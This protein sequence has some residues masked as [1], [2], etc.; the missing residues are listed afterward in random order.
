MNKY[1]IGILFNVDPIWMG[2]VIYILNCV[3]ALNLLNEED[4]PEV[5]VF[6]T[7]EVLKYLDG[8]TY[9]HAFYIEIEKANRFKDFIMSL[10]TRRNLHLRRLLKLK[11]VDSVFPVFDI[12][13]K[14]QLG[15]KAV[16]W[17]ADFQYRYYPENFAKRRRLEKELRAK[18]VSK[19]AR[20]VVFSSADAAQDYGRFYGSHK[21]QR[22]SVYRFCSVNQ[23]VESQLVEQVRLKFNLNES[24]F[25]CSNQWH[26]HKNH[27]V[28]LMALERCIQSDSSMKVVLT[29]KPYDNQELPHMR[30]IMRLLEL[31][32]IKNN[33]VLTGLIDRSEQIALMQGARAVIQPSLFEGWSTV[34]EDAMSLG[35]PLVLSNLEVNREQVGD[36]G[37]FFNPNDHLELANILL[38]SALLD[39]ARKMA[40]SIDYE[41]RMRKSAYELYA[42]LSLE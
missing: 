35:V 21:L 1:R 20:H 39:N 6:Y 16:C 3:N 5:T 34:C 9:P 7:K 22:V 14:D 8:I 42:A 40:I 26:P 32:S 31:P 29:G 13:C 38:N 41:A 17:I 11:R 25:L 18:F 28:V 12:Y 4:K 2:G 24:Y 27:E 37:I 33:V 23:H 30:R 36:N 10:I 19:Y 15:K